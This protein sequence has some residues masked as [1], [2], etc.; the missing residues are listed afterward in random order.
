MGCSKSKA[1]IYSCIQENYCSDCST[2]DC[3]GEEEYKEQFASEI[4]EDCIE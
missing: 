3:P 2:T 1:E 4:C